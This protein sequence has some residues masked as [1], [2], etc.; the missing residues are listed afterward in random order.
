MNPRLSLFRFSVVGVLTVGLGHAVQAAV[1]YVD[2]SAPTSGQ[3]GTSPNHPFVTIQQ[4]VSASSAND[5]VHVG[6]ASNSTP[7]A[8]TPSSQS[9]SIALKSGVRIE[10][11][12]AGW[13]GSTFVDTRNLLLYE[14]TLSGNLGG[15][16]FAKTVVLAP[17][18]TTPPGGSSVAEQV[19]LDGVT[20]T[21]GNSPLDNG[22]GIMIA[23]ATGG[24]T[25]TPAFRDCIITANTAVE[26]GGVFTGGGTHPTFRRCQFISNTADGGGA[27]SGSGSGRFTFIDCTFDSNVASFNGGAV[28]GNSR[29]VGI[30]FINCTFKNNEV[31]DLLGPGGAVYLLG[32]T[33]AT[34][35]FH[36]CLFVDNRG[37]DGGA[38]YLQGTATVNIINGTFTENEADGSGGAIYAT[39]STC[40]LDV[41]NS[42][43]WD[44]VAGTSGP[45][46]HVASS[47]NVT[48]S[49]TDY[50]GGWPGSGS[51]NI[52]AAP[53]F[54][55]GYHLVCNSRGINE[56]LNTD[57][58]SDGFDV[59]EDGV[60]TTEDIVD[61][62]LQIRKIDNVD[63]GAFETQ[64]PATCAADVAPTPCRDSVVN[65]IDLLAVIINWGTCPSAPAYCIGDVNLDGTVNV[66]D[67]LAVIIAWGPCGSPEGAPQ[68]VDDCEDNCAGQYGTGNASYLDCVDKCIRALCE[69]ETLPPEDC[70]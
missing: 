26:G 70:P 63:M 29:T 21:A 54:D 28:Y 58:P 44:D 14:T 50:E 49:Y 53:T 59:D 15:G 4:A 30:D 55:A 67:L 3:T 33:S 18:N 51:N 62:D 40:N 36:N 34:F 9:T 19:N 20:I 47:A 25:N 31:E 57:V 46:I 68:S 11:G 48:V 43:M 22:A 7:T 16:T 42:I 35:P 27:A 2:A 24:D 8:Y 41:K 12:Y 10:G 52:N 45:E 5:V 37:S 17:V 38:L 1:W 61:R 39:G 60:T 23:S 6:W 56:G 69:T 13:N 65:V 66:T 64:P 32:T